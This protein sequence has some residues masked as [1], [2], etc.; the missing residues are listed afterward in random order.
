MGI[1]HRDA[2]LWKRL[3]RT[4]QTSSQPKKKHVAPI[5]F[6]RPRL[7]WLED[8][9]LLSSGLLGGA[10]LKTYFQDLLGS[11]SASFSQTETIGNASVGGFLQLNNVTLTEN[12]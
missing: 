1:L 9:T 7:E 4:R 5:R 12:A 10:D 3:F 8:R 6:C 2:R 11:Q